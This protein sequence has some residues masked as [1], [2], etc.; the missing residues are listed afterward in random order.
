MMNALIAVCN[1]NIIISIY[2]QGYIFS[3]SLYTVV[4]LQQPPQLNLTTSVLYTRL[5]SLDYFTI[6]RFD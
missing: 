5:H 2:T 6:L 4:L 1:Q 3:G